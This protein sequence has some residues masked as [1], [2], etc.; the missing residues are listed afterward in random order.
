MQWAIELVNVALDLEGLDPD[1]ELS[2]SVLTGEFLALVG[3]NKSGKS[4][5]LQLCAGLVTPRRGTV[6][7]LGREV[8]HLTEEGLAD[9]RLRIGMVQQQPALLSNMTLYNNVALPLRYHRGL[10]EEAIEPLVM[11]QLEALGLA[12]LR[13]RFPAQLSQ[14]EARRAAIA[15][16]LILDQELLLLDEPTLGL[17]ADMIRQLGQ[18]LKEYRRSRPLTILAA[19]SAASALLHTADR[20]GFVR[21]GRLEA[22]GRQAELLATGDARMQPYL[23]TLNNH[24]PM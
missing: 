6:R 19:M 13:D 5:I 7:V 22:L 15:R 21:R 20:V 4:E 16:A 10:P 23:G 12:D 8:G 1:G 14:G 2:L 17:D 9:L 11:A 24:Q 18:L 3:P